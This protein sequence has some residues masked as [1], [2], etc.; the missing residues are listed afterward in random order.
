MDKIVTIIGG[1]LAGSEL[2]FQLAESGIKV[3]L[4]EMRPKKMTEAHETGFL[5]ELLCSNSLKAESL[6]T[7]S[8][9]LK[10]EME[11]LNSLIIKVAKKN[12]VPAGNAL[13][14]D[15]EKFAKEI[16]EILENHENIKVIRE[17]VKSIPKDRPLV[18]ASGPLTSHNLS[19]ELKNLFG[20]ELYFY[21]AISPIVDAE[22][23]DYSKCFF[24]SRYNKG[25][26]DY[27]NCPLTEEEFDR[28]YDALMK[29]EKVEF[30]DFEKGAVFEGCMPIEELAARGKQTLLFGPMRPVGLEHPKTGKKYYAVVQLRKEDV[31]GRA[32]N[33][34]GFQT[35]MKIGAQKEVFRLIPGL[36]NAEFLRYGSIH[37]NTYVRACDYLDSFFRYKDDLLFFA[38]QITGVEGYIESA[39]T[40][41]IIAKFLV[42]YF[43]G[44]KIKPFPETTALG[45][46]SRYVSTHKK[47]YTPSNFHFGMLPPLDKKIRDKKRK[48]LE[49]SNRALNALKE[50]LQ[51]EA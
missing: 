4:Y 3:V 46:L 24:K 29:A 26:S 13:A 8:G 28:F 47:D 45:A 9:L 38:G 48:K 49:L 22:S 17:E 1:G 39:A 40:S 20:G 43:N 25:E 12:R 2:A 19:K 35:K 42:N 32:Y 34:V 27:L 51:S 11:M 36:E 5:G 15:R 16:T 33:I 21:D 41:L 30:R 10:A 7:A 14:V 44:K 50:Y 31:E 37:R 23:I 18:V 6:D